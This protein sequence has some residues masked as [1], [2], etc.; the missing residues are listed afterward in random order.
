MRLVYIY[1]MMLL[2]IYISGPVAEAHNS[3]QLADIIYIIL[4][5]RKAEQIQL[6]KV[7]NVVGKKNIIVLILPSENG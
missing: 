3:H 6:P 4:Y 2:N 1:S 7:K 5:I